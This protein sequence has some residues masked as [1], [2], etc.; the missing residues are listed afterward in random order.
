M[1]QFTFIVE[2]L[3]QDDNELLLIRDPRNGMIVK[4]AK[5]PDE[6]SSFLVE[7]IEKI[8]ADTPNENK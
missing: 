8:K 4:S 5:S 3:I 2:V 6:L 1:K 7:T